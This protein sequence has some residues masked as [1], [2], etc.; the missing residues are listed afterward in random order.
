MRRLQRLRFDGR[1]TGARLCIKG[2]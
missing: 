2:H 1:S